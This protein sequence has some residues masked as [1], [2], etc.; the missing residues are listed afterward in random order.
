MAPSSVIVSVL[1]LDAADTV[2]GP[3]AAKWQVGIR[4]A[5][6][7]QTGRVTAL[8][9]ERNPAVAPLLDPD[10]PAV[11]IGQT[12]DGLDVAAPRRKLLDIGDQCPHGFRGRL[13]RRLSRSRVFLGQQPADDQRGDDQDHEAPT[14][15]RTIS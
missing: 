12:L 5:N 13:K 15:I 2:I 1:P 7:E 6:D 3:G 8:D 4:D 10:R 11:A 14:A 9:G